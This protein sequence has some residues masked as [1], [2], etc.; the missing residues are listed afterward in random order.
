MKSALKY[1]LI[2]F[3][4]ISS[5]FAQNS[6]EVMYKFRSNG[7]EMT[8]RPALVLTFSENIARLN[9]QTNLNPNSE[10]IQY[11]DYDGEKTYQC[12]LLKDGSR[13]TTV[14]SFTNYNVPV[15][16]D[17]YETIL[18]YK[19]RKATTVIRSNK[20][21]IWFTNETGLKGTP[22]INIG[23]ALG[24]VLKIVR[25]GNFEIY[26][27]SV[28]LQTEDR[29]FYLTSP[30]CGEIV[31]L[32]TYRQ[33]I[34]EA[35]YTTVR[36]FN[37]EIINFG[38]TITNPPDDL[39][40]VTYRYS[41]GTVILKKV[42]LPENMSAHMVF[43]ELTERSNGDAYDRTGSCFIIPESK[44]V[45]FLDALR[46]DI[47][48]LPKYTGKN[49]KIYQGVT[50]GKDYDVPI[51]LLRFITPFGIG[52]YNSQVTVRGL[53]WEDSVTYKQD[54]TDLL[55][56]LEG[57]V[58][59]GVFIGC[60]D[61]GGHKVS[62]SLKYHPDE[63]DQQNVPQ[64][65]FWVQPLVNTLNLMEASGQEYGTLFE[66]DTL[67]VTVNIP[68]GITNLKLRYI[69]TGHGGWGGGDEFNKKMNEIFADN[70]LI[71]KFIPWRD[72]CGM[73]R[74][75]NPASG[76]FPNGIS[77]SDYSRSGWCPGSTAIPVDIPLYNLGA[78]EHTF[79]IH[80]PLGAPE[81]SSFSS[82]NV[83]AV[84]IGEITK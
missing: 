20:I 34:T 79:R 61:R 33:K 3:A 70:K 5:F 64:K 39:E 63:I 69:S 35:N 68:A 27:D 46:K 51:E 1:L 21:E 38:D 14:E 11:I 67:S 10:E 62:L 81:G 58:W 52:S 60:Y 9:S 77:S 36:V 74:E 2:L 48:V 56:T 55:G 57:E 47:Y 75:Y 76:N 43:A 12:A 71:Y 54:I 6:G 29:G 73:Y 18:G 41:K 7:I 49:E 40:N 83:S 31:D 80:I 24:L 22:Q 15:L 50:T 23:P 13:I 30:L 84:L 44:R 8:D 65:K 16:T 26:A 17:D 45:S 19:C 42:R 4:F 66:K 72:D 82:W 59:I 37:N 78:G 32:P 53:N 28:I 25:N